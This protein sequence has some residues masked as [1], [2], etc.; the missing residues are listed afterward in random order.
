MTRQLIAQ[1]LGI[2]LGAGLLRFIIDVAGLRRSKRLEPYE[3][4]SIVAVGAEK[5]VASMKVSLEAA[6]ADVAELRE[7]VGQC[8]VAISERDAT[9]A[10]QGREIRRLREE[11]DDLRAAIRRLSNLTQ[12]QRRQREE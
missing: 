10:E 1:I 4:G 6:E 5:A 8:Q 2:V 7:Q 3:T 11:H 9:I 12:H